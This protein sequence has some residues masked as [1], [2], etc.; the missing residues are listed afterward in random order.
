M[1]LEKDNSVECSCANAIGEE[2]LAE[3]NPCD[4][5]QPDAVAPNDSATTD[6]VCRK[7][8]VL[9]WFVALFAALRKALYALLGC[10]SGGD[11]LSGA[12]QDCGNS[13]DDSSGV[14]RVC[15]N[16]GTD[17]CAI[18]RGSSTTDDD[19]SG[20]ACGDGN[21]DGD[22]S[23]T[24]PED[25]RDPEPVVGQDEHEKST[26]H[27]S[28]EGSG[29]VDG[30]LWGPEVLDQS[31]AQPKRPNTKDSPNVDATAAGAKELIWSIAADIQSVPLMDQ[32]EKRDEQGNRVYDRIVVRRGFY[33]WNGDLTATGDYVIERLRSGESAT[34]NITF[35]EFKQGKTSALTSYTEKQVL[36]HLDELRDGG[37]HLLKFDVPYLFRAQTSYN[38]LYGGWK[39]G[40][41]YG[42]TTRYGIV[43]VK[44]IVRKVD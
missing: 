17:S 14:D 16:G 24:D 8:R 30:N 36:A 32:F 33:F 12:N 18:D 44:L 3:A 43:G 41:L 5:G 35:T 22:S 23:G 25:V 37:S 20:K 2:S 27:G 42:E 6:L 4:Q 26:G 29:D 28:R 11:G 31:P 39:N 38:R 10:G 40:T 15:G 34:G 9:N 7:N 21:S 13:G 1:G 19:S